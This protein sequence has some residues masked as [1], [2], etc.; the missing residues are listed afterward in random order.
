MENKVLDMANKTMLLDMANKTML[1]DLI[2]TWTRIGAIIVV[3]ARI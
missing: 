1:L 3:P 2:L